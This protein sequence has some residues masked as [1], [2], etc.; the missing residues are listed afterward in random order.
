M[1]LLWLTNVP[2]AFVIPLH[3]LIQKL[4]DGPPPAAPTSLTSANFEGFCRPQ[5]NFGGRRR[6]AVDMILQR[7]TVQKIDET[8]APST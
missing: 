1:S 8:E 4:D 6:I 5:K 7:L 3:C 2:S